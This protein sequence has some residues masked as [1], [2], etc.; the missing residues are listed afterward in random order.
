MRR[1]VGFAL[2]LALT[3]P[4]ASAQD[5]PKPTTAPVPTLGRHNVT[6]NEAISLHDAGNYDAAIERYRRILAENPNDV[7]V[8]YEL[9]LTLFTKG[10]YKASAETA[11]KGAGYDSKYLPDFLQMLGSDL[12]QLGQPKEAVKI[13]QQALKSFPNHSLLHFNLGITYYKLEQ[14][15]DARRSFQNAVRYNPEHASAHMHLSVLYAKAKYKIP[16]LLAALR[17]LQLESSSQRSRGGV[18]YVEEILKAGAQP[19]AK[20][21][22]IT[23]TIDPVTKSDEGDFGAMEMTLGILAATD[24]LEK[25]RGKS[26]VQL[27]VS[28]LTTF[29]AILAESTGEKRG[30]GFAW[31]Y[32]RPFFVELKN[33][34]L[35]EPFA[36][37]ILESKD[38]PE[39]DKWIFEHRE[40]IAALA[41][42]AKSYQ[43]TSK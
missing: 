3:V 1:I 12:D 15:D 39:V 14:V 17:F 22:E 7:L 27:L 30:S 31:E 10:D 23:I 26:E 9:S 11:R 28:K 34:D 33:R 37:V 41:A 6:I 40:R 19:G 25:N 29:I 24:N 16:S 35:V 8:L 43:W 13:Y 42:F 32:Y 4:A 36:Y 21:N 20:P 5:L 18:A 38:S 2:F